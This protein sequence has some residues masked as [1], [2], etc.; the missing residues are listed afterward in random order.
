MALWNPFGKKKT[1][2]PADAPQP[3]PKDPP[4]VV[5]SKVEPPTQPSPKNQR[6]CLPD[7]SRR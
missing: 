7:S 3:E 2:Q 6:E 1:D 4:A 5:E